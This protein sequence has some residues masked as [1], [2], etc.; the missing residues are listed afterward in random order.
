MNIN[1]HNNYIA[2]VAVVVAYFDPGLC[3]GNGDWHVMGW[4][5]INPGEEVF[6]FST[7]STTFFIYATDL[8]GLNH[9]WQGQ[10]KF[11]NVLSEPFNYCINVAP[12]GSWRVG[13]TLIY[14]GQLYE[15]YTQALFP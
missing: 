6:A 7:T 4:L 8:A 5:N 11:A 13:M 12:P 2:K 14:T 3:R 15:T 9:V 1:I 10:D